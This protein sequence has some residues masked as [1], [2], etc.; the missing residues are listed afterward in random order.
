MLVSSAWV[1]AYTQVLY[2]GHASFLA[3]L[4]VEAERTFTDR[5]VGNWVISAFFISC[6]VAD[7]LSAA[8]DVLTCIFVI[9]WV[10]AGTRVNRNVTEFSGH[11]IRTATDWC[12]ILHVANLSSSTGAIAVT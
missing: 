1:V 7:A 4:V 11:T 10:V 3:R 5:Q 8:F 9:A 12:A 2:R 6:A